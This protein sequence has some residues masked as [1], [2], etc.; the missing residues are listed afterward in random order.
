MSWERER[1]RERDSERERCWEKRCGN[2]Q[3][4][5]V[6]TSAHRSLKVASYARVAFCVVSAE[7]TSAK[8]VPR[9]DR[10]FA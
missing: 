3:A 4:E 9:E 7:V 6:I 10:K 5:P 1:E 2:C 8:S